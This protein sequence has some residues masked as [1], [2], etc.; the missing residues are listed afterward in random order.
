MGVEGAPGAEGK[1]DTGFGAM[2][3]GWLSSQGTGRQPQT[4]AS[5]GDAQ[6]QGHEGPGAGA[7]LFP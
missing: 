2:A 4:R 6:L 1:V 5:S 3:K 7:S